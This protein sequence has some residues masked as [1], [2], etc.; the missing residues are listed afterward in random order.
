MRMAISAG[1]V[2]LLMAGLHP[3][4][5]HAQS[6]ELRSI[7][8]PAGR[9]QTGALVPQPLQP[10]P[11]AGQENRFPLPPRAGAI[12]TRPGSAGVPPNVPI[13]RPQANLPA[14]APIGPRAPEPPR[15]PQISAPGVNAPGINAP[16]VNAPVV[17]EVKITPP[18]ATNPAQPARQFPIPPRS[19]AAGQSAPGN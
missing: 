19:T 12:P 7:Q 18:A 13:V 2:A 16:R 4:A 10:E 6:D 1:L 8:S 14:V 11:Q 5:G 15:S 3:G 17:P 9:D